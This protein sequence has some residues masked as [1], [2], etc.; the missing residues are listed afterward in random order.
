MWAILVCTTGTINMGAFADHLTSDD[1][2]VVLD[3]DGTPF[4]DP[5]R[6]ASYA[7]A[8]GYVNWVIIEADL[9]A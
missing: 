3:A 9:P 2:V 7:V 4:D 8:S 5:H 1:L 6:A